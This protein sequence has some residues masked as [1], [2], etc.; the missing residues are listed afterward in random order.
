MGHWALERRDLNLRVHCSSCSYAFGPHEAS[1]LAKAANS[2]KRPFQSNL[3]LYF[4]L[5]QPTRVL[6]FTCAKRCDN[7][8]LKLFVVGS[9]LL[10]DFCSSGKFL[11]PL[12]IQKSSF[13]QHWACRQR[14]TMQSR[15]ASPFWCPTPPDPVR[16]SRK[17]WELEST[18][19]EALLW[20]ENFTISKTSRSSPFKPETSS[21]ISAAS[22]PVGVRL[23]RSVVLAARGLR[24]MPAS[25]FRMGFRGKGAG[26][27]GWTQSVAK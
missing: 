13:A 27:I 20:D 15:P 18:I 9:T 12:L 1:D 21:L 6:K 23:P 11:S 3:R 4:S 7:T 25:A 8:T 5:L 17:S 16:N 2:L 19:P 10:A 26:K 14:T 24:T 22:T